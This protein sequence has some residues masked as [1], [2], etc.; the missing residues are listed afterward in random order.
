MLP[1]DSPFEPEEDDGFEIPIC[2]SVGKER[3]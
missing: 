1:F 2:R 3:A